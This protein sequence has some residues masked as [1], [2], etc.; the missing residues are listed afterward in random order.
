MGDYNVQIVSARLKEQKNKSIQEFEKDILDRLPL[1]DSAYHATSPFISL[2]DH[3]FGLILSMITQAKWNDGTKEF[4]D[5]LEPMVLQGM[6][7]D[8]VW[9]INYSEH[10]DKPSTR[11]LNDE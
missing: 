4:L 11:K 6:G 2:T 8:D 5:W 3:G 1:I 7:E 10:S 9:A